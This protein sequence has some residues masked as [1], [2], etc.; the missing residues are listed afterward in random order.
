MHTGPPPSALQQKVRSLLPRRSLIAKKH[1]PGAKENEPEH[2]GIS[3]SWDRHEHISPFGSFGTDTRRLATH[4]ADQE[5]VPQV[6]RSLSREL[7]PLQ[8]YNMNKQ[9]RLTQEESPPG[10]HRHSVSHKDTNKPLETRTNKNKGLVSAIESK[11]EKLVQRERTLAREVLS[12]TDDLHTLQEELNQGDMQNKLERVVLE[13]KREELEQRR[14]IKQ[15]QVQRVM[16]LLQ[17]REEILYGLLRAE[18]RPEKT[19]VGHVSVPKA[20]LQLVTT[21]KVQTPRLEPPQQDESE[22]G[23][24]LSDEEDSIDIGIGPLSPNWMESF[25]EQHQD[26][27][28]TKLVLGNIEQMREITDEEVDHV[29]FCS[30]EMKLAVANWL[31][32]ETQRL[33]RQKTLVCV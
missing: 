21:G 22:R 30:A 12:L 32:E 25:E 14:D 29:V 3:P 20:I 31:C 17:K 9:L 5:H 2:L 19:A 18:T 11:N 7:H 28:S 23:S 33:F 27:E 1:S 15:R 10:E 26:R 16:F 13:K 6:R 8:T 24:H 4:S